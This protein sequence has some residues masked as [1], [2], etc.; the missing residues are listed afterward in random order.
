MVYHG[1]GSNKKYFFRLRLQDVFYISHM[2]P[3]LS[4]K[5]GEKAIDYKFNAFL[6]ILFQKVNSGSPEVSQQRNPGNFFEVPYEINLLDSHRRHTCRRSN[7]ET[8][9]PCACT[10]SNEF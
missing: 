1:V 4:L 2:A 9:S 7:D 3:V 5:K 10:I 8:T 6:E